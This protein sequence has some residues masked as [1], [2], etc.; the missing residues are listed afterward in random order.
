M[1]NKMKILIATGGTGGHV[2][3][4]YSLAKHF[5]DKN[6]NVELITDERGY[7]FLKDYKSLKIK[8]ITSSPLIKWNILKIF[9]SIFII[10]YSIFRSLIFLILN[11]PKI[12]FGMGGY[13]SF[14]ICIAAA[15]LKIKFIIYENN[16]IIGKA[17]R[18][19][20]P[21]TEEIFV[22]YKDLEGIPRKYNSKVYE[23]G[24][25]IR[26]EIINFR[27]E[28]IERH[29]FDVINIL[30]LGGSQAAKVFGE[31]LP[32]VFKS[33]KE[34]KIPLKIYQQCLKNQN[35]QLSTFYKNLNIDFEIFNFSNNIITYFS[36][37]N[38]A[39]TRSGASMLAELI[40]V[41]LPFISVPLPT[42]ADNHQLK[43]ALYYEKKN[44]SY[45]IEE[46]DLEN[47]LFN[48]IRSINEDRSLIEKI[49]MN[50]KQYSDKNV[51]NNINNQIEKILNEKN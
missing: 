43:N 36:K 5:S 27:N 3:P 41:N 48:L 1:I 26:K 34:S 28:K 35:E 23:I 49:K 31:K 39:I 16:L 12:I 8:I 42:S 6:Y 9:I 30:V 29:N 50:Q 17:N 19:L 13:S 24:N 44:F 37:V 15:I 33:C 18:Y 10:L 20:L 21:F 45:L 11:R 47:K 38:L 2:F 46:K 7:N 4:A 40:N 25:L 32:Q 22:S 14:P 51:F